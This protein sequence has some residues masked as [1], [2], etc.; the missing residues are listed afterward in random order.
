MSCFFPGGGLLVGQK[1]KHPE[2]KRIKRSKKSYEKQTKL[3]N[4]PKNLE[5]TKN[6]KKTR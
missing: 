1:A 3:E 5:K 2:Y 6:N 4:H